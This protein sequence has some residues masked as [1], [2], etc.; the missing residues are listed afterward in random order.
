MPAGVVAE[1]FVLR[2]PNKLTPDLPVDR[3]GRPLDELRRTLR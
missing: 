2:A 3:R 1:G